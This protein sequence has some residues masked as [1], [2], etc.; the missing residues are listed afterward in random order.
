MTGTLS[1]LLAPV[2]LP[3][4]RRRISW[5]DAATTAVQE[6]TS[7]KTISKKKL[8]SIEPPTTPP[9]SSAA[10]FTPEPMP[11]TASS[12]SSPH[13]IVPDLWRGMN[14]KV[15]R[16]DPG[17]FLQRGGTDYAP[18]STTTDIKV[19]LGYSKFAEKGASPVLLRLRNRNLGYKKQGVD[20]SFL[21]CFPDE[22]EYLYPPLTFLMPLRAPQQFR[23]RLEKLQRSVTV[24]VV[25]VEVQ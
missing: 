25:T 9:P 2:R 13:G 20:L 18:Q 19:A 8:L 3:T 10:E 22:K 4:V 1:A 7:H 16:S 14:A 5:R 17:G 23:L 15:S 6:A 12:P 11:R 24:T 21:S